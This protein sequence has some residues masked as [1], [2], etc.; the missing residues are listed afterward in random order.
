MQ[1][2]KRGIEWHSYELNSYDNKVSENEALNGMP[3]FSFP[4]AFLKNLW[5]N[6]ERYIYPWRYS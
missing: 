1:C 3:S 6:A 2:P 5:C 4:L